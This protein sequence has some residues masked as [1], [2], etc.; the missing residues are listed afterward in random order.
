[1]SLL[2]IQQLQFNGEKASY[3]EP[4]MYALNNMLSRDHHHVTTNTGYYQRLPYVTASVKRSPLM[5]HYNRLAY[6]DALVGKVIF[7]KYLYSSAKI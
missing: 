5:N 3:T 6:V 7:F 2:S 4:E 1:M